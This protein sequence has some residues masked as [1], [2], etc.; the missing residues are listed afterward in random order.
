[1][2]CNRSSSEF[3]HLLFY[4]LAYAHRNQGQAPILSSDIMKNGITLSHSSR[5]LHDTR[6]LGHHINF[7]V[8]SIDPI[9]FHNITHLGQKLSSTEPLVKALMAI[10]VP[11]FEGREYLYNRQSGL[12]TDSQDPPGAWAFLVAAGDFKQGGEIRMPQVGLTVRLLPGDAVMIRGRVV[13]HEILDWSGG[14]RISLPHFTHTSLWR[15]CG[16]EHLVDGK[17]PQTRA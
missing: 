2:A 3:T 4:R 15:Y 11:I 8:Q 12:H 9:F 6:F 14:Q 1:M 10:D 13:E 5:M 17:F 16:L 7:L